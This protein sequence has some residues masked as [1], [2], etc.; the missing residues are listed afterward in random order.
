MAATNGTSARA[1]AQLL[2]SSVEPVPS[3][4]LIGTATFVHSI[5]DPPSVIAF[6]NEQPWCVALHVP[7]A[8]GNLRLGLA[9]VPMSQLAVLL[10][11]PRHLMRLRIGFM[12]SP[13]AELTLPTS[14]LDDWFVPTAQPRLNSPM[15]GLLLIEPS[16][17]LRTYRLSARGMRTLDLDSA[18]VLRFSTRD[19]APVLCCSLRRHM[20]TG[21][22]LLRADIIAA[23][24]RATEQGRSTMHEPRLGLCMSVPVTEASLNTLM[25]MVH[26]EYAVTGQDV[27][28]HGPTTLEH[29]R[30]QLATMS[31]YQFPQHPWRH[32]EAA[33]ELLKCWPSANGSLWLKLLPLDENTLFAPHLCLCDKKRTMVFHGSDAAQCARNRVRLMAQMF[34]RSNRCL[35]VQCA[36]VDDAPVRLVYAVQGDHALHGGELRLVRGTEEVA[37]GP[38]AAVTPAAATETPDD[39]W[40]WID[41]PPTLTAQ[42]EAA[43]TAKAKTKV[44]RKAQRKRKRARQK[45]AVYARISRELVAGVIAHAIKAATVVTGPSASVSLVLAAPTKKRKKQKRKKRKR[46]KAMAVVA[47]SVQSSPPLE[48]LTAPAGESIAPPPPRSQTPAPSTEQRSG[49]HSTAVPPPQA[50]LRCPIP[51]YPS[52][53]D[54][55]P[56]KAAP[57]HQQRVLVFDAVKQRDTALET[58]PEEAAPAPEPA[59]AP[60]S[61]PSPPPAVEMRASKTIQSTAAPAPDNSATTRLNKHAAPFAPKPA[62]RKRQKPQEVRIPEQKRR[63]TCSRERS[64]SHG[65]QRSAQ[66]TQPQQWSAQ[67]HHRQQTPLLQRPPH[68]QQHAPTGV[69][70]YKQAQPMAPPTR[71]CPR[72]WPCSSP[73]TWS[74]S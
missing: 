69:V 46:K 16:G 4:P 44:Q 38:S 13:F 67:R 25:D 22:S 2:L 37:V 24:A 28:P 71:R 70:A 17:L 14:A 50:E 72:T 74:S 48:E 34:E 40:A 68:A 60:A 10:N 26:L 53:C 31:T 65:R 41:A 36:W 21:P 23:D 12:L 32:T 6:R 49:P 30:L 59:P 52:S 35:A 20:H 51:R 18:V 29:L 33:R 55:V 39:T 56:A 62:E 8:N 64:R 63:T 9:W 15:F 19:S 42:E 57:P 45:A 54:K 3:V 73:T 7:T 1:L 43:A 47:P 61:S 27:D 5:A 11:T 66:A 58:V